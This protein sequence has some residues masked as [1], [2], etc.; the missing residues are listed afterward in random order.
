[1][2]RVA[3]AG[4]VAA[5]AF[6]SSAHAQTQTHHDTVRGAITADSGRALPGADIIITMAPLRDSRM[7]ETDSSGHYSILF[8]NGTGDYLVHISA[9]GYQTFRK[10]VT[11]VGTDSVFIVDA[12]L[13]KTGAQK[14]V[15]VNV[16]GVKPKPRR[17]G[18]MFATGVGAAEGAPAGIS[19]AVTPDQAGNLAAIGATVPGVASTPGG[20]SVGGI[21]AAQNSTT[22]NG[23]AFGGADIPRDAQTVVHV[24][25]TAYDPARGWF[26][27]LNENI[28]LVPG[29]VFNARKAHL[30]VDAPALQYTDPVSAGLGQR[31]SNVIGNFGGQGATDGDTYV[32]NYGVEASRRSSGTVSLLDATPNL[33]QHAGVA[34]DSAARVGSLLS[35][36]GVP[37][38]VGAPSARV[39]QDVSFIG[40]LDHAPYN[41][42]DFSP[43]RT[44]WGVLGYAK[45][46]SDNAVSMSPTATGARGGHGS[47]G[48]GM[49]EALYST[50][51]HDKYL[52]QESSALT[53]SRDNT[54]PYLTLPSGT[55]LVGSSFADGTGGLT[56]LDFG[57]NGALLSDTRKWTWE[58]TSETQFYAHDRK[59][60][61][62]K[63]NADSR[64]DGVSQ[65]TSSNSLG[66][67]SFNSLGEL[68]AN[69]PASYT[70]S[71]NAPT[72]HGSVW[73]GFAALSDLWRV[74]PN[75]QL[76]YGARLEANRYTSVP[77]YNPAVQSTFGLRTDAA[78]NSVHISPRL[79]FTWVHQGSGGGGIRFGPLGTFNFGATKYIR[80][81]VGEFRNILPAT[82]LTNASVATGLPGGLQTIT[83][84]GAAT[85]Q[86]D[87][88]NYMTNPRLIPTQCLDGSTSDFTDGAP[89]V[90][91][92]D[93]NYTAPRS[94]RANLSYSSSY[95]NLFT[96]SVE[97]LYSLNLNQPGRRDA[98]FDNVQ[99]FTLAD[100]GRPVFVDASSIVDNTGALT[101]VQ[102]RVSPLFGHVIDN[103]STLMSRSRQITVSASPL[104]ENISNWF[105]SVNYTLAST[106]SQ[107]SGFDGATFGSPVGTTWGRGDLDIRHQ[108][109]MQGG[110]SIKS[111]ALTFFGRLQSGLPFTPM[112]GGD[113]NGDGLANDRAFIFNPATTTDE[114]LAS[115]TR[116]LLASSSPRVRDC[117]ARQMG[118]AAER[119][120]CEG[121]WTTSLNAQLSYSGKL[122]V[123]HRYGSISLN[124][125]N[126]L[127]GVD[128]L[129]HGPNHLRGWG[130]AAYPDPVLYTPRGFDAATDE[131]KY[132]VNPRFGNTQPSNILLRVPFRVT[133]DI[134]L[135]LGRPLAQQQ[136]N[137]WIKPGRGGR[138][139]PK[140]SAVDLERR[141]SRNVPDP[142]T[143]I[144]QQSDSLLLT[145]DQA[146]ALEKADTAYRKRV[147]SVWTA[148]SEYLAE[149]PDNFNSAEA[150]KRQ[151]AAIDG[152]WELTKLDVQRIL[153]TILSPIQMKLLPGMVVYLMNVKGKVGLQFIFA[154]G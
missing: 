41:W 22:L 138:K 97:G 1:M 57:G 109:L 38:R 28:E 116:A 133:L 15:T 80:G 45:L 74:S 6:A 129:L 58:T 18:D 40:R 146:E 148:V 67:F 145:R 131:F 64:F 119:N 88:S 86:P 121:P 82:L 125:T 3:L 114:S 69:E 150:L 32:Y 141:Y 50:Y 142:Y 10:R 134:S 24:A 52:T 39:T 2:T 96:Y 100:E 123:T 135:T 115:A 55:V 122:P 83:C 153:P 37:L 42:S 59:T 72:L 128:Q 43:A 76:M 13:A 70:R 95:G 11:R 112:V 48:I 118:S 124:L 60:H 99:R 9:L 16:I 47:N 61:R 87:W 91:L 104:L 54:T 25:S 33:L 77:A 103:V 34:A 108:L 111:F 136:L 56:S 154:G 120:S 44:T 107:E 75:L 23:M 143:S 46:A 137:K 139:G 63:F 84:V 65:Q 94:W 17:E 20:L 127:G 73:N 90:Q 98:N 36:A 149:L 144:L 62:V 7:T 93:P 51:V 27:G 151:Q 89:S 117:L 49:L 35:T 132:A 71:L 79:G 126:P 30:T 130:T 85:P 78:P 4:W 29:N 19:G 106:R 152:A 31:F 26:D 14:L 66:A 81:G 5:F 105:L 147:D 92:F 53:L 8:E 102:S 113:V 12:K 101:S 140:L 110:Y 21:G 68:A